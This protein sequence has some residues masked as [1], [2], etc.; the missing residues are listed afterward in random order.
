[1]KIKMSLFKEHESISQNTKLTESIY[2]VKLRVPTFKYSIQ[3]RTSTNKK[4]IEKKIK[5]KKMRV[6]KKNARN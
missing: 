4:I 6:I 3:N 5:N 2:S 1:M